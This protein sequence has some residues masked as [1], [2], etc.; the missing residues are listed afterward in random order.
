[1]K[2][3]AENGMQKTGCVILQDHEIWDC[4]EIN[5]VSEPHIYGEE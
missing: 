2:N 4:V 3:H 1:M 5:I